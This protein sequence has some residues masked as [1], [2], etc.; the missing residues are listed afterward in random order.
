MPLSIDF[1]DVRRPDATTVLPPGPGTH[2]H[3][4]ISESFSVL[5]AA[6]R[7][8]DGDRW[9]TGGAGVEEEPGGT[10]RTGPVRGR[11]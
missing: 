1:P 3:R 4:A 5:S 2:F 9:L 11:R 7:L 10:A 6:V 8:H